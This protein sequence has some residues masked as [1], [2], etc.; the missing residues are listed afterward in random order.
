MKIGCCVVLYNPKDD[1]IENI[2]AYSAFAE[3][4][5]VVD[6]STVNIDK[7]ENTLRSWDKVAYLKQN[8]NL[9]I[10]K[11]LNIGLTYLYDA[12][13][14]WALTMDQDS[15]FPM[16]NIEDILKL[17][18]KYMHKYSVIGLRFDNFTVEGYSRRDEIFDVNEW[19]TSGNFVNL[20]D[21]KEVG[22]FNNEL[23]IDSVDHEFC[24]QLVNAGKRIGVMRDYSLNHKIGGKHKCIKLGK[25]S[26][27]LS[28][29]HPPIRN[30]YRSRNVTYLHKLDKKFYRMIYIQTMLQMLGAIIL[31]KNKAENIR[32]IR[33]GISD[34][35]HKRLGAYK[36]T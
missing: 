34:G 22:G 23:F 4:I 8:D 15:K 13:Y 26:Y 16:D 24:R 35:K 14:E 20:H 21:F 9:G 6:N 10:A 25:R 28:C 17:F 30:Y 18:E 33:K 11:A 12:G 1:V 19:I 5:V 32:M 7:I 31:D 27:V 2:N 3:K 36:K 29:S